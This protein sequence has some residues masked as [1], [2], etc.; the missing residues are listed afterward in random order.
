M[1]LSARAA[2]TEM[3]GPNGPKGSVSSLDNWQTNTDHRSMPQ[4]NA[5]M[6]FLSP[7][8]AAVVAKSDHTWRAFLKHQTHGYLCASQND[9]VCAEEEAGEKIDKF[10]AGEENHL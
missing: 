3:M 10:Y 9:L 8:C 4:N 6:R 7:S 2:T 1:S 5:E